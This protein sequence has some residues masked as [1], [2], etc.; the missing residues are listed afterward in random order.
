MGIHVSTVE[1]IR[2]KLTD[3]VL[4]ADRA[5]YDALYGN[6]REYALPYA[7][8]IGDADGYVKLPLNLILG[9]L[10]SV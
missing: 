8:P 3:S 2:V 4:A 1:M 9:G 6:C 7:S 5:R 10:Q